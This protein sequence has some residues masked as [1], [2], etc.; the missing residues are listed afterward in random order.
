MG[1]NLVA[2]ITVR[3]NDDA[4]G[5]LSITIATTVVE[6]DATSGYI[7]KIDLNI[8]R[9]KGTIGNVSVLVRTVGGGESWD[10]IAS[11]QSLSDALDSRKSYEKS[12]AGLDYVQLD[13]N[14]SFAVRSHL[15]YI[16]FSFSFLLSAY[17]I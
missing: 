3:D 10:S 13:T 17:L 9:S 4:H 14:V 11:P 1:P 8:R 15:T 5:I 16:P 7:R 2:L 6:E 12:V